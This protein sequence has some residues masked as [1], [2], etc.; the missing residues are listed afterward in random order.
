MQHQTTRIIRKSVS[1]FMALWLSGFVFIFCCYANSAVTH[2]T[3]F[4]PMHT[5]SHHCDGDMGQNGASDTVGRLE[6]VCF[7]CC[8]YLPAVFDKARKVDQPAPVTA[9]ERLAI[10][11]RLIT[12]RPI[13]APLL[14]AYRARLTDKSRTFI[15]TQVFRI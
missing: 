15:S 1:G 2:V 9:P 3:E 12:P 8:G 7:D 13:R 6:G 5:A 14:P 4:C 11:P 10:A